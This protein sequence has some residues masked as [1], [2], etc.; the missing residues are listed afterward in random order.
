MN[1]PDV[2]TTAW[3]KIF[4]QQ[5]TAALV[6]ATDRLRLLLRVGGSP[7]AECQTLRAALRHWKP[8]VD[9][10]FITALT[11]TLRLLLQ[12]TATPKTQCSTCTPDWDNDSAA[13][14]SAAQAHETAAEAL[15][16]ALCRLRSAGAT[17]E[18]LCRIAQMCGPY[19]RTVSMQVSAL[20][21]LDANAM[22][23]V[24]API[25]GL[26]I[27]HMRLYPLYS[28][29]AA[30]RSAV[31]CC[32]L[33]LMEKGALISD[34]SRGARIHPVTLIGLAMEVDD[35]KALKLCATLPR[36]GAILRHLRTQA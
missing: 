7:R 20:R 14:D 13:L 33:R 29:P 19:K 11:D 3:T 8:R 18:T 4:E 6:R 27:F 32:A 35:R 34:G 23:D 5:D 24:V 16:T 21:T 15:T 2:V 36:C 10:A 17:R 30:R 22:I 31:R 25:T 26:T 1:G 28:T 9:D 12:C